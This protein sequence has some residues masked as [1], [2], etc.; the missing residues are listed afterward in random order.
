[1]AYPHTPQLQFPLKDYIVN[2]L[3]FGVRGFY[4]GVDW[5]VHL[6]DDIVRR[7]GTAVYSIG[8]GSVVYSAMH[9]GS[10]SRGNWGNVII[11]AHKNPLT[12]KVFYA[13][14][15][16]LGS[17][18]KKRGERVAC[19]EKIGVIGKGYTAENGWWEPH[20]HFS[21]YTGPWK[22]EV[23]PGYYKKEHKRTKLSYW[24]D[25]QKFINTYNK[26][27]EIAI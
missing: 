9:P 14:Y 26:K 21:I 3:R 19:G 15:A 17:R 7:A 27:K 20:L 18:L 5:G 6:G 13:L 24:E 25:P 8:R 16:H 4:G 10:V 1:M 11:V 2:A 12:R 23:L 22:G